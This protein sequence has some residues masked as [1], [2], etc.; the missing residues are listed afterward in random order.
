ME[1][2]GNLLKYT[3]NYGLILGIILVLYSAL[4]YA[5]D[6]IFSKSLGY[7]SF[8]ITIVIVYIGQKAF[9][10]KGSG[11][12]I[13][14]GR[15]LVAGLLIVVFSSI[16]SS[17]FTYFLY[18]IIDPQLVD[19]MLQLQEQKMISSGKYTEEQIELGLQMAR[20][21]TTPGRMVIMG[22]LGSALMGFIISLITSIF[23]KKEAIQFDN[24]QN[25]Q[26]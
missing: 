5:T 19:K 11:G 9:R 16:I 14:Y 25:E 24:N 7:V 12:S 21:F 26:N 4:L 8:L 15:A 23:I 1:Q 3:L 2:K 20:K 10:D 18:T 13:N 6:L 17:I 22:I